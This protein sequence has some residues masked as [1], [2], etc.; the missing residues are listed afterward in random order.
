MQELKKDMV[1]IEKKNDV[2]SI[3]LNYPEIRN[4]MNWQMMK[5][6][7]DAYEL[8]QNSEE[9][10]VIVIMGSG[11]FFNTGGVVNRDDPEEKAKYNEELARMCE[12]RDKLELPVIAAVNGECSAGGM[13]QLAAADLAVA[14]DSAMFGFP[15][16]KHG[17]FPMLVMVP[18]ISVMSRKKALESFYTGELFD[19]YEAER[20]GFLNKVTSEADFW[21]AIQY[22]IDKI[23]AMDKEIMRIGRRTFKQMINLPE[24]MRNECGMKSLKEIWDCLARNKA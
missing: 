9:I 11:G 8:A 4:G 16:A 21:P 7:T 5:C 18:T 22:Y 6:I 1:L 12:T 3:Q 15:E 13:M 20:M 24:S 2:M 19:A 10:K 23:T 17:S 14:L